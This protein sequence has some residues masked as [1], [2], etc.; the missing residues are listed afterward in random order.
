MFNDNIPFIT[1]ILTFIQWFG[2]GGNKK[3]Q[4]SDLRKGWLQYCQNYLLKTRR[5][6]TLYICIN[7]RILH[8][9]SHVVCTN[10]S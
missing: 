1:L 3:K 2:E 7:I 4:S 5:Y 9:K 6:F 8:F 10:I